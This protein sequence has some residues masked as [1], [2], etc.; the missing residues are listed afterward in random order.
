MKVEINKKLKACHQNLQ[1]LDIKRQTL[2]KQTQYLIDIVMK[3][4]KIYEKA[5][6]SNYDRTDVFD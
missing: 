3:Y 1:A 5:L 6:S 2:T 4:Q